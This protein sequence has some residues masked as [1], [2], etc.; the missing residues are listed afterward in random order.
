MNEINIYKGLSVLVI[1]G[2]MSSINN[3][4]VE[5]ANSVPFIEKISEDASEI[6]QQHNIYASV[7]IA[8]AILESNYGRSQLSQAPFNNL[9]GI[10]GQYNGGTVDFRTMEDDGNAQL[11]SIK[12]SFRKYSTTNESLEDY[13]NLMKNGLKSN[14]FYYMKTWKSTSDHYEEATQALQGAYATDSKY[15]EKLNEIIVRHHLTEFDEVL[16]LVPTKYIVIEKG[17]TLSTIAKEFKISTDQLFIWNDLDSNEIQVGSK[18]VIAVTDQQ[19]NEANEPQ[20]VLRKQP[21]K[22]NSHKE[23]K[24]RTTKVRS[25]SSKPQK[26]KT[27]N[28]TLTKGKKVYLVKNGDSIPSIAK[29]FNQS[30]KVLIEL[31]RLDLSFVYE[32]QRLIIK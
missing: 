19:M 21:Q 29:K 12:S 13:A 5:A 16:I 9:F 25:A 22:L 6:A 27:F 8:Q 18:L 3:M 24:I 23:K 32:G 1:I 17:D 11:F 20:Q 15:A 31:N 4:T 28:S 26:Y 30:E 2:A 14:P 7:M 10:K